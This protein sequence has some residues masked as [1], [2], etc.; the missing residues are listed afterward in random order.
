MINKI[1]EHFNIH[2]DCSPYGNGHINNTYLCNGSPRYIL[3]KINQNVFPQPENVMENIEN[4]TSHLRAKISQANGDMTRETLTVIKTADGKLFY[5]DEDG[6]AY[7]AY[8]FVEGSRSLDKAENNEQLYRVAKAFGR[9]Q[10]MLSDF[11]A[12]KLHTTIADFHNT[13]VR[14][15]QLKK[16]IDENKAGRLSS[17]QKEVDFALDYAKCA[18]AITNEMQK[19]T[20]PLRV[21]HNDTKL[22]NV[23]FDANSD[24]A[25]CVIDLDT[26]MPGSY[27][28]DFG[29][30][31]RFAG[32][33][34]AEDEPDL[35]KIYFD[36]DK[37][38]YFAKGYLS[39]MSSCLTKKEK[40]LLPLSVLIM[41]YECGTRFLADHLNGDTYFKIHYENH[42]LV[43]ARTQFKL[44]R[45]I[46]QKLALM[47]DI[48]NDNL[49]YS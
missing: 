49:S 5:T 28:Y 43:R 37:F 19:G 9:F 48:I 25:L 11:D 38:E 17:V 13:P 14:V 26:I 40:E 2:G 18:D 16:A 33:S 20:V 23:L 47:S 36:L 7:R 45:D 27:L 4:V 35:G 21:T 29:D 24:D 6:S 39:E 41:T 15:E 22:N 44:V 46:E 12:E 3:Q 1:L 8:L 32:S 42:N 30:A 34:G 31:L 10:K